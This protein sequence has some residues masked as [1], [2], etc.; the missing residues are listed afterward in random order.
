LLH[1]L[2]M[3]HRRITVGSEQRFVLVFDD[4]DEAMAELT[5]FARE[6]RLD[7]ASFTAIGA[8]ANARL[9]FFD[10]ERKDY[11]P[12][13]V[14]EQVEVVSLVGDVTLDE[15]GE[16]KVHAHAVLATR[17]GS[18]YG[19]HLLQARVRPTLE[20]VLVEAPA[21]LKRRFDAASGLALIDLDAAT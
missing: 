12:I 6:L 2:R 7:A 20:L 11:L 17:N 5:R 21:T 3:K 8:F 15:R 1:R 16:P 4:G 18:T 13:D 10:I 19:G 9:G 14:D